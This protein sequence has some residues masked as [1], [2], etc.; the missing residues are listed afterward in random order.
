MIRP[1][2]RLPRAWRM[3]K[4]EATLIEHV[5]GVAAR[6]LKVRRNVLRFGGDPE[7]AD[8]LDGLIAAFDDLRER[9][10]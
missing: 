5:A 7:T 3:T 8:D 9:R 2:S 10:Q 4:E 1:L 6:R